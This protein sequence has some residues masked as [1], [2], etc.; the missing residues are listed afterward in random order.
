MKSVLAGGEGGGGNSIAGAGSGSVSS[1]LSFFPTVPQP[2]PKLS[3]RLVSSAGGEPRSP[4]SNEDFP[5]LL[6]VV[7]QG[8][9]LLLSSLTVS[10]RGSALLPVFQSLP[11]PPK[12]KPVPP[13]L[14]AGVS[15]FRSSCGAP[16]LRLISWN[17]PGGASSYEIG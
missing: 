17:A 1:F 2:S 6:D 15:K 12:L 7:A 3:S 8:L 10:A 13:V 16:S 9:L 14:G 4:K 5:F 11:H